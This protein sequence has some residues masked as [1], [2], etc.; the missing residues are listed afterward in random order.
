MKHLVRAKDYQGSV[1]NQLALDTD[2]TQAFEKAKYDLK[3]SVDGEA[4]SGTLKISGTLVGGE[5]DGEKF[6]VTADLAGP[7]ASSPDGT[8]WGFN[9]ENI[10]CDEVI[11]TLTGGCTSAEVVY[12]NLLE[13]IGPGTGFEKISTAGRALTSVPLPAAAWLFG[14][15]LLALAGMARRWNN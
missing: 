4:A 6:T 5:F 13:A 7:Y 8:L 9:T 15:G 10:V 1:D 3:A 14:T 2:I 11:N 12:L